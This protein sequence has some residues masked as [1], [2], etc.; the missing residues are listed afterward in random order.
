MLQQQP[1]TTATTDASQA[2]PRPSQV[3]DTSGGGSAVSEMT[4]Q[5]RRDSGTLIWSSCLL[6]SR[7]SGGSTVMGRLAAG[8]SQQPHHR[9]GLAG[10]TGLLEQNKA[11]AEP[12][13]RYQQQQ[14]QQCRDGIPSRPTLT[15]ASSCQQGIASSVPPGSGTAA[16]EVAVRTAMPSSGCSGSWVDCETRAPDLAIQ[17]SPGCPP[18][19]S[20][21]SSSSSSSAVAVNADPAGPTPRRRSQAASAQDPP[22]PLARHCRLAT[23]AGPN[24]PL[25]PQP[26]P[27]AATATPPLAAGLLMQATRPQAGG[28]SS[29]AP[30]LLPPLPPAAAAPNAQLAL[31][32]LVRYYQAQAKLPTQHQE[33]RLVQQEARAR[34]PSE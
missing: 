19:R 3:A 16:M 1:A 9:L 23:S 25:A 5:T 26:G 4:A 15:A 32:M 20:R 10:R 24:Q 7:V 18:S 17:S 21:P 8:C 33:G 14:Q 13:A 2:L 29:V 30:P 28:H 6:I 12:H 11:C 34:V 22:W 27:S 31:Q